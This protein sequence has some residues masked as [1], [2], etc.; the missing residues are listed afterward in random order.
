MI[1]SGKVEE[2]CQ[3]L[4]EEYEEVFVKNSELL[5]VVN[6]QMFI[7]MV[8][9]N[10]IVEAVNFARSQLMDAKALYR[11]NMGGKQEAMEMKV[12]CGGY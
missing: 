6:S 12:G 5:G 4:H 2:A 3:I 7:E 10:E 1:V 9:R 11:L 8:G